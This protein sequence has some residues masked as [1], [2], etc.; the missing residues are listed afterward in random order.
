M[1][2]IY[3][4]VSS[5]NETA[6]VHITTISDVN[7]I[8]RESRM[9]T[10]SIVGSFI[11]AVKEFFRKL[12]EFVLKIYRAIFGGG[13][14]S[15]GRSSG[16]GSSSSS[17]YSSPSG[18]GPS[19][20]SDDSNIVRRKAANDYFIRN[21]TCN[22]RK[23]DDRYLD[24]MLENVNKL[25]NV[26]IHIPGGNTI[27][28]SASA[29]SREISSIIGDYR[30]GRARRV[31]AGDIAATFKS[32]IL[33]AVERVYQISDGVSYE[34]QIDEH[35]C[36][37]TTLSYSVTSF[38]IENMLTAIKAEKS[39]TSQ[40]ETVYTRLIKDIN[41][42]ERE[43]SS[44]RSDNP[45]EDSVKLITALSEA[46]QYKVAVITSIEHIHIRAIRTRSAEYKRELRRFIAL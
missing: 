41:D 44:M 38:D 39:T 1:L 17:S 7:Y 11:N 16:N 28:S 31:D 6:N 18:S 30:S 4:I 22:A 34:S 12:K 43:V 14:G 20:T 3:D 33:M 29:I 23:W 2:C 9:L 19:W 8:I 42:A 15:S 21:F 10:E 24:K 27:N 46:L 36:S 5:L 26:R 45:P 13:S 25:D 32:D 35:I 37:D 40:I